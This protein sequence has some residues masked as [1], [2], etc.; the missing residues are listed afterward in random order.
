LPQSFPKKVFEHKSLH[1]KTF[2]KDGC[3]EFFREAGKNFLQS[4]KEFSSKQGGWRFR[5]SSISK[6]MF[7]LKRKFCFKET[8]SSYTRR[9]ESQEESPG[10]VNSHCD[11]ANFQSTLCLSLPQSFPKKVFEHKSL[12]WKTFRK[13]G[14]GEFFR[15]A[16][17]NFLQSREE[18]S[19]N[20]GGWRFRIFVQFPKTIFLC[21]I[22]K[23]MFPLR[24]GK[25]STT[26][27]LSLPQ[28]FP[29]RLF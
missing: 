1:W 4:R 21:A 9:C 2:R 26:Y 13:D 25:L 10:E 5:I 8:S 16:G 19:S 29:N 18:F 11:V 28:N 3:G 17:K 23:T 24:R 7:L 15:E 12:H 27:M 14:C 22:S 6:T 20:Q